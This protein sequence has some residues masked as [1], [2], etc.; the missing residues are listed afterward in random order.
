MDLKKM[1]D[2]AKEKVEGVVEKVGG[3]D[4]IKEKA[5]EVKDIVTGEG[6]ITDKAKGAAEAIRST[7]SGDDAPADESSDEGTPA[8]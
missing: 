8:A 5:G 4:A 6:S 1:A 3:T 7:D 2:E